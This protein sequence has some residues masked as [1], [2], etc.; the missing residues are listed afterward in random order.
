MA[1]VRRAASLR[2]TRC[3]RGGPLST[4]SSAAKSPARGGSGLVVVCT[5]TF[6]RVLNVWT[7]ACHARISADAEPITAIAIATATATAT[8]APSAPTDSATPHSGDPAPA[9]VL[10]VATARACYFAPLHG[11]ASA[12]EADAFAA[13]S[14][15]PTA[16]ATDHTAAD[17]R[18]QRIAVPAR[19]QRVRCSVAEHATSPDGCTATPL[20]RLPERP[21]VVGA[22][23]SALWADT[24]PHHL[25]LTRVNALA[26]A[27]LLRCTDAPPRN[28]GRNRCV[29]SLTVCLCVCLFCSFHF[30]NP[31]G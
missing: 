7:G 15:C 3:P 27:A 26:D 13:E 4:T 20:F 10:V 31:S 8:A 22:E 9:P 6:V 24:P 21:D 14:E 25:T 5:G 17:A 1:S 2:R 28:C 29:V 19:L 18:V 30:H 12:A 11:V 16:R 23:H